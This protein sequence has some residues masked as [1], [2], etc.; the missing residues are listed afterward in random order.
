MA[1][2]AASSLPLELVVHIFHCLDRYHDHVRASAVC[3]D[4]QRAASD[5]SLFRRWC[6]RLRA[7]ELES[8]RGYRSGSSI[9][10]RLEAAL[11]QLRFEQ[12]LLLEEASG[13]NK[14]NSNPPCFSGWHGVFASIR[15]YCQRCEKTFTLEENA[16]IASSGADLTQAKLTKRAGQQPCCEYHPCPYYRE[17]KMV[18][19]DGGGDSWDVRGWMCCQAESPKARGCQRGLHSERKHREAIDWVTIDWHAFHHDRTICLVE[20]AEEERRREAEEER[21]G[22]NDGVDLRTCE[23]CH[24]SPCLCEDDDWVF[25]MDENNVVNTTPKHSINI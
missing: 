17:H 24:F 2:P 20:E 16:R 9:A 7:Q 15:R 13:A 8:E 21:E 6:Y 19:W 25:E 12:E 22:E 18:A 10:Q 3:R 23:E 5:D 1:S 4:W 11:Q 14:N